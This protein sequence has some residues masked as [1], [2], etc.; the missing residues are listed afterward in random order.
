MVRKLP[1][2]ADGQVRRRDELCPVAGPGL[3]RDDGAT[4]RDTIAVVE[5]RAAELSKDYWRSPRK[6]LERELSQEEIVIRAQEI[7]TL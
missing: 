7:V 6:R 3:W 5:V 1:G 2:G 4:E